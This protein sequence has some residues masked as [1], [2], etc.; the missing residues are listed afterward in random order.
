MAVRYSTSPIPADVY[1]MMI[2]ECYA[3]VLT[4]AKHCREIQILHSNILKHGVMSMKWCHRY[5]KLSPL[6]TH[7]ERPYFD[8]NDNIK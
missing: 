6:L 4:V 1:Y 3:L 7:L 2:E 5:K 8:S